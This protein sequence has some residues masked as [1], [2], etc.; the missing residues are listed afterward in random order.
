MDYL[1]NE[2][3]A[4][5]VMDYCV[6]ARP[7][8]S[9]A[10]PLEW[11]DLIMLHSASQFHLKEALARKKIGKSLIQEEQQVTQALSATLLKKFHVSRP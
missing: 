6:R 4:T 8:A 11:S 5:A 3:S 9:L 2:F 7:G 10:V 1:R